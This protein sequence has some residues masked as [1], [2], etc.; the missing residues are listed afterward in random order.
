HTFRCVDDQDSNL[1]T[2]QRAQ[3]APATGSFQLLVY[4]WAAPDTSGI[5]QEVVPIADAQGCVNGVA[6]GPGDRIDNGAF[7]THDPIHERRFPAVWSP[8]VRRGYGG[9]A[10][11]PR[12]AVLR[13]TLEHA[14]H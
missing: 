5:D 2:I 8:D 1:G 14:D 13:Q 3:G 6:C 4:A 10:G 11:C 9:G 12:G 7:V